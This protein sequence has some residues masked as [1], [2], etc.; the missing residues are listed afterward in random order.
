MLVI[1]TSVAAA[2]WFADEVT[3]ATDAVL[4]RV[5]AE[6]AV[7]PALF[8]AE[9]A[10]VLV[11]AERR[12]RIAPALADRVLGILSG[13]PIEVEA[14]LRAPGGAVQ[15]ARAHGLTVYD[16]TYLETAI[17]RALPLAT[18]DRELQRAARTAGV[19]LVL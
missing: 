6:G 12:K 8:P 10:N 4:E 19:A 15:L 13:L 11:Q 9:V 5:V 14:S 3:P 1:D 2:W 7:V 17:R 16:A 18:L